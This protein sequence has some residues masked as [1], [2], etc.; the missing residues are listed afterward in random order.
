MIF[1]RDKSKAKENIRLR[2]VRLEEDN[3]VTS[4]D[5]LFDKVRQLLEL[6]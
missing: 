3:I 4:E 1:C 5:R 2:K 6:P